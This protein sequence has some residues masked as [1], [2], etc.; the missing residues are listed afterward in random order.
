M[1]HPRFVSGG[2]CSTSVGAEYLHPLL[3][4]LSRF[5]SSPHVFICSITCAE[6]T[7]GC[8]FRPVDYDPLPPG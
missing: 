7:H 6:R 2:S 1:C 5:V 4:I 8:L 3:G